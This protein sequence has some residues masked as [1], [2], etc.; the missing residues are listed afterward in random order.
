MMRRPVG[1]KETVVV[2]AEVVVR[3]A[4]EEVGMAGEGV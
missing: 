4:V 3:V 1:V 2:T